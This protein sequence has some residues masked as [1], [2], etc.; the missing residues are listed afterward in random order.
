QLASSAEYYAQHLNNDSQF[1]RGLYQNLLGRGSSDTE[2]QIWL[3]ELNTG[4][5]RLQVVQDFLA[6]PA[7]QNAYAANVFKLYL[8]RPPSKI[9]L[10]QI[11]S[12]LQA[13][14]SDAAIVAAILGSDEY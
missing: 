13:G 10:D 8:Q 14:A 6:T 5:T 9:E 12:Q 3:D 7:Y 2:V 11:V 4:K 1:I